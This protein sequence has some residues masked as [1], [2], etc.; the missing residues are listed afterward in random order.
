MTNEIV[1]TT[2]ASHGSAIFTTSHLKTAAV[3]VARGWQVTDWQPLA[4][5]GQGRKRALFEIVVPEEDLVEAR[6]VLEGCAS[7]MNVTVNVGKYE[8]AFQELWRQI[9]DEDLRNEKESVRNV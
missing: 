9:E 8:K 1:E 6:L 5:S 3:F 2:A 7:W 4:D